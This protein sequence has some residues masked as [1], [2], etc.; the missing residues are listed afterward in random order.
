MFT[1]RNLTVV[2]FTVHLM[3]I[4]GFIPHGNKV[5]NNNSYV[6]NNYNAMVPPNP[7]RETKIK[8]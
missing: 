7:T 5:Q 8:S 6:I 1:I 2:I 4:K 3:N